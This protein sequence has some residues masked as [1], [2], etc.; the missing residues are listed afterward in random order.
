[1]NLSKF[2]YPKQIIECSIKTSLT[3][4]LQELHTTKIKSNGNKLPFL[5]TYNPNNH[6]F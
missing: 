1:M 4:S 2:Q 5:K 6:I 3:V